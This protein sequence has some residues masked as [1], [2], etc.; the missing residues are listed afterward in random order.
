MRN[1]KAVCLRAPQTY[2]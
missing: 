2:I 1:Q